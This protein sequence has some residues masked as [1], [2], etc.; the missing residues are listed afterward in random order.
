MV[1]AHGY[2][3]DRTQACQL[4][5]DREIMT[6]LKVLTNGLAGEEIAVNEPRESK[7]SQIFQH[8]ATDNGHHLLSS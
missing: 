7:E 1:L 5:P 3:L 4:S 6:F 8:S 2:I